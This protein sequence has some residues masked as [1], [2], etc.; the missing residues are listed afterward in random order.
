MRRLHPVFRAYLL[1][2]FTIGVTQLV[3]VITLYKKIYRVCNYG[4]GGLFSTTCWLE[5]I[6]T[7]RLITFL[8]WLFA[9]VIL[10]VFLRKYGYSVKKV[11]LHLILFSL[12][13]IYLSLSVYLLERPD[14]E[15]FIRQ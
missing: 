11:V 6:D 7:I 14:F 9:S 5:G 13:S 8:S 15:N 2:I 10:L 1:G 3:L 4:D 12:L